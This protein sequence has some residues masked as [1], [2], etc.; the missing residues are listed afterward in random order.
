VRHHVVGPEDGVARI[1][2]EQGVEIARPS[3][4]NVAVHTDE[5][6]APSRVEVGGEAVTVIEG[7][8]R[9]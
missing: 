1:V 6:G 2:V 4:I 5:A 8:V 3:R 9:L 7:E